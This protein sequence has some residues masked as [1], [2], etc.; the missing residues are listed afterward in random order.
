MLVL[1]NDHQFMSFNFNID[2]VKKAAAEAIVQ[3]VKNVRCLEHGQY[4][5]IVVKGNG[6]FEVS[7]CCDKLIADVKAR[8]K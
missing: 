5:T 8:F 1:I 4:A 7:G 2:A 6:E 3:R